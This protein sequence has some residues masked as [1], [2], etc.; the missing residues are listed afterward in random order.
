MADRAEL[1][2]VL[3]TFPGPEQAR[4][5]ASLLVEKKLAACCTLLDGTSIY[6]WQGKKCQDQEVVLLIKTRAELYPELE[7]KIKEIHPYE[8]PEIIA[9]PVTLASQAYSDW[10]KDVTSD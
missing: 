6:F 7:Q 4:E 3:T 5:A 8:V 9:L 2:L 1:L 10:I